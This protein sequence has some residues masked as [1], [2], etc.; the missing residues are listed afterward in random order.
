MPERSKEREAAAERQNPAAVL[1]SP[2]FYVTSLVTGFGG[3]AVLLGNRPSRPPRVPTTSFIPFNF[4]IMSH[5]V[6][7]AD[8]CTKKSHGQV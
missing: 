1:P 8:S 2:V 4:K 3:H 5:R 6:S 7:E